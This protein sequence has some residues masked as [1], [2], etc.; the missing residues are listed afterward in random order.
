MSGHSKWHSIRHQKGA[1]DQKRAAMF[2]KLSRNIT[3]AARS[4]G[5]IE[6]N[7]AL[8]L[9]VDTAKKASMPKDNIERAI[10]KGTGEDKDAANFDE[11][12][13]EGYGPDGIPFIFQCLTDN[14]NR[15]VSDLKHVLSKHGGNLGGS[16]MWMFDRK[17]IVRLGAENFEHNKLSEELELELID[18][19]VEDIR[20]DQDDVTLVCEVENLQKVEEGVKSMGFE[21]EHAQIEYLAK[22]EVSVANDEQ[23]EKVEKLFDALDEMDDVN[24]FYTNVSL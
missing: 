12:I 15:T 13:Y 24:D 23:K 21:V 18:V 8:R 1:A 17:G 20:Q 7:F 14:R 5:D 16:V 6:T 4:G 9:A 10:K 2:T 3:V 19:G 22:E 11:I